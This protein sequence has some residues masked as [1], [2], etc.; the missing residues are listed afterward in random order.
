[1]IKE[2]LSCFLPPNGRARVSGPSLK[3]FVHWNTEILRF[4]LVRLKSH[5]F[6][7]T[8]TV[9]WREVGNGVGCLRYSVQCSEH[10]CVQGFSFKKT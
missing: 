10:S 6:I 5:S 3:I 1:M 4:F 8:F 7:Y 2:I 9:P